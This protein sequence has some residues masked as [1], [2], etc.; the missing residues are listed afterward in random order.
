M[1]FLHK[2][3][4]PYR[5]GEQN[6]KRGRAAEFRRDFKAAEDH[7]K[8]AAEAF[9]EHMAKKNAKGE[10]VRP[11]HLVMAGIC[12]TRLGRNEDGLR[13]LDECIERKDIPDAFLHAGYAAAKM[14]LAE[15]ARDYWSKYPLWAEQRIISIALREQVKALRSQTE[16]DLAAACEAVAKAIFDQDLENSRSKKFSPYKSTYPPKRR[17]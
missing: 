7:F 13:V 2:L 11:S 17:Y 14:G 6:F 3:I 1:S 12:Y 15:K 8:V 9:D 5:K 16:P 10:E 4:A